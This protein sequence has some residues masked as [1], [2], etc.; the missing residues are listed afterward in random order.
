M[1]RF[2][3]LFGFELRFYL[4][5]LSTWV[6]F[7]MLAA[8]AF[9]LMITFGG[10]FPD[11]SASIEGTDGNVM[12]NSPHVLLILVSML[13]LF[14]TLVVAAIAG[15]AGYR[16]FGDGMH[17][18]VFTKPI[19]KTEYVAGRYLG[20]V[21]VNLIVLSGIAFGLWLGGVMPFV[22]A[23][24]FGPTSLGAYFWPYLL[25]V[26]PNIAFASAI[27]LSMALL[28]TRPVTVRCLPSVLIFVSLIT[29]H[30]RG[31]APRSPEARS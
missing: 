23:D 28:T 27:F 2:L 22:E 30:P 29:R 11:A 9:L 20:T 24:R 17:S 7:G 21:T 31:S 6:Y 14:G 1:K 18:L 26:L 19:S 16:D 8:I 3:L 4:R 12:V 25:T 13:G 10:A 15:N 5:R